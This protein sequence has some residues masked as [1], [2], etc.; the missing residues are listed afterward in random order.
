MPASGKAF[1]YAGTNLNFETGVFYAFQ[2]AALMNRFLDDRTTALNDKPL[3]EKGRYVL[4]RMQVYK[5]SSHN[6]A[7]NKAIDIA[8]ELELPLVVCEMLSDTYPWASDRIHTFMLQGTADRRKA[9]AQ[10]GI[11]YALVLVK[12]LEEATKATARL[13]KEA[14]VLVTEDFPCFIIPKMNAAMAAAAPVLTLAV[15]SNGIIPMSLLVKEEYAARTIRPKIHKLLPQHT[16]ILKTPTLKEKHPELKLDCEE[17]LVEDNDIAALVATCDIDHSVP[18]SKIYEGGEA[19]AQKRLKHFVS[20]ILPAYDE[21][22]NKPDVDGCSRMSSYLHFGFISAH[23]IYEAV[24]KADAPKESKDAYLEELIVRR[25]LSYNFTRHNPRHN[26]L[27]GTADWAKRTMA[28][29]AKDEHY[30]HFTAAQIEAGETEDTLWNATQRELADT[31]ELHNYMRMLW[32]KKIIEW[33]ATYEEAFHLMEHLNNKYALDGRNPNSYTGISWC[34]GKHDRAWGPE[35]PV[36]GTLRYL[37]SDSWRRKINAKAY[38][39]MYGG[40]EKK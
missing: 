2:I 9:L 15:D 27:E 13:V 10:K 34:F 20:H 22:R 28:K 1:Q 23:Q 26:S 25:E 19:A 40:G 24:Q 11:R 3:N 6:F 30:A 16:G 36:F 37:S 21:L 7:L 14:A 35:R 18:A 39:K 12:S 4:Y 5:R 38:I 8:N 32:G 31:G 33:T 29:H 17:T